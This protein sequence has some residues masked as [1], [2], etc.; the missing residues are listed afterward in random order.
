VGSI[1]FGVSVLSAFLFGFIAG[2]WRYH[3]QHL[4]GLAGQVSSTRFGH[5]VLS[6]ETAFAFVFI[7]LL[8]LHYSLLTRARRLGLQSDAARSSCV[9]S[10]IWD[11]INLSNS[12]EH[13]LQWFDSLFAFVVTA[14]C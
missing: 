5:R 4:E 8:K 7:L 2:G 3:G 1:K 14:L 11:G 6:L 10:A 13:R 9:G 12:I